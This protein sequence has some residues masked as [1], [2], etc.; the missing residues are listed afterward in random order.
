MP[1]RVSM[2]YSR[3]EHSQDGAGSCRA[4]ICYSAGLGER[5]YPT[6]PVR[7]IV[8]FPAGSGP[9]IVGRIVGQTL[10]EK[11]GQS[12]VVENLGRAPAAIWRRPMSRMRRRTATC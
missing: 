8:G 9:D 4:S 3:K 11:L 5:T 7:L 10:G 2:K 6:R 1:G 12:V